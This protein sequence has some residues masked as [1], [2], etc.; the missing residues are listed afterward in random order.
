VLLIHAN[1][2]IKAKYMNQCSETTK[3]KLKYTCSI[4]I[5]KPHWIS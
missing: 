4:V 2:Y 1:R 5:L 3:V